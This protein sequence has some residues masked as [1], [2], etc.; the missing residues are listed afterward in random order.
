MIEMDEIDKKIINKIQLEFPLSTRPFR[1]ISNELNIPEEEVIE[2]LKRLKSLGAIRRIG[3]IINTRKIGGSNTLVGVKVPEYD[4]ERVAE[5]INNYT[6]VSHNYLRDADVNIWFTLSAPNRER[7]D[8][9]LQ[10]IKDEFGY[11]ILDLP[12]INQ[13]KIQVYF[14]LK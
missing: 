13:Y 8:E 2:R 6:E 7:I 5:F 12:T 10:E 9:I 11:P 1:D 4:I 14:D 3:P